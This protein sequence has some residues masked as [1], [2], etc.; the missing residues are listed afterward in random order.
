[1]KKLLIVIVIFVFFSQGC[2][3]VK[4]A[5][6]GLKRDVKRI[7]GDENE[8]A[9]EKKNPVLEVDAWMRENLW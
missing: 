9:C 7:G 6:E 4:G 3:T 2:E 1:M 5:K 8:A